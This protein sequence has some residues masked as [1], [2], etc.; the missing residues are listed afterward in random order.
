MT[1]HCP[2]DQAEV[3]DDRTRMV[4]DVLEQYLDGLERG[5]EPDIEPLVAGHPEIAEELRSYFQQLQEVHR[6]ARSEAAE[7]SPP[8][9]PEPETPERGRLGDFRILREIGRGGMGVVYEA[10]QISLGRRVALKVLPFAATLDAKQLQRFKNEAQAAAQLHHTHIVPI[11]AVGCDRGVHYYAMQFI[12][13]QTLA[14]LIAERRALR[15][16]GSGPQSPGAA[17]S[18]SQVDTPHAPEHREADAPRAPSTLAIAGRSTERSAREPDYFRAIARLGIQA[19]EA[20]EHAHQLGVLHRDIKPANLLIDATG[21]LWIADFGLARFQTEKPLTHSGDIVGTL[22]YMSPEQALAKR[23]LVDHRTDIY[24]L[25]ATLYEGLTL[26]PAY[27]GADREEL[28]QQIAWDDPKP[29]RRWNPAL[30]I[31][32]ETIVL[33]AMAREPDGR[34]ATAQELAD[35]LQCF[36]ENRPIHAVRPTVRERMVKWSRRHKPVLAVAAAAAVCAFL[37][38]AVAM[39]VIWHEK[40]RAEKALVEARD[41]E[42]QARAYA[43]EAERQRRRAEANFE[44]ALDGTM[45]L[46]LRLEQPR[47]NKIPG[48]QDLQQDLGDEGLR[49][50][51]S[52]LEEESPDPAV[53]FQTAR[54]YTIMSSVYCARHDVDDAKDAMLKGRTLLTELVNEAPDEPAYR[55]QL[56]RLHFSWAYLC[57][58]LGNMSEA[59]QEFRLAAEQWRLVL[60]LDTDGRTLNSLAW[61]YADCPVLKLR[62]PIEA[63]TL[64]KKAVSL[65][66]LAGSYWN[67]LGVAQYRAG[68]WSA[69][70]A[71]LRQSMDKSKGGS[72]YDW[73]FLSMACHRLGQD[74]KARRWYDK[75]IAW[76]EKTLPYA[77]DLTRYRAEAAALLGVPLETSAPAAQENT[78]SQ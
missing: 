68:D 19:A 44:K 75:A 57:K 56:G 28:L 13:G 40:D 48:I 2:P 3:L 71:A 21:H 11:Y 64:A 24:A 34:Y 6:A 30:P 60:P 15:S 55:R 26:E 58:S 74:E 62:N 45:N 1:N 49:F 77:E 67:T 29:P 65:A 16:G 18:A 42:S 39:V 27:P 12:E 51:R 41:Q 73:F 61:L 37:A 36:L 69:S 72:A 54:A 7:S 53:R 33:K 35:D 46:L 14:E 5:A 76:M 32:L 22:R 47:W 17:L 59:E 10:E 66:P 4:L 9:L 43:Q 52:F 50:Y 38:L 78:K 63:V 20:L 70:I 23:A 31:E 8:R 25:G